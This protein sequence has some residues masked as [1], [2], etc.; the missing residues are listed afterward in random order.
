MWRFVGRVPALEGAN[1]LAPTLLGYPPH[2]PVAIGQPVSV[3]DDAEHIRAMLPA[4]VTRLHLIGHSYGGVVALAMARLLAPIVASVWVYE[5]V[6]FSALRNDPLGDPEARAE[7]NAMFMSPAFLDPAVMGT[8]AWCA[9][10]IEYWNGPG[11]FARL[12]PAQRASVVAIGGKIV[13]ELHSIFL[14]PERFADWTCEA[15]LTIVYGAETRRPAAAIAHGLAQAN[16][17]AV[18]E[19]IAGAT[20]M[21]PLHDPESIHAS[22]DAHFRRTPRG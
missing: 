10:F 18:L 12:T 9:T 4:G 15:P 22:L 7:A 8:E 6:T 19:S 5:P 20:H 14:G 1:I 21:A 16:P 11:A 2:K 17:H 3:R 13:A